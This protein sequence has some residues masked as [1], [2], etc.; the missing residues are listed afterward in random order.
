MVHYILPVCGILLANVIFWYKGQSKALY[1]I[2]WSPLRWWATTSLVTN[3]LTLLSWWRLIE[4]GD[5]WRA[6]VTWGVCSLIVDV[7]LNCYYFGFHW[8]G[9]VALTLCAIGAFILHS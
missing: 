2:D 4:I 5:V 1:G 6:G 8:K 7:T 9:I 3:Y